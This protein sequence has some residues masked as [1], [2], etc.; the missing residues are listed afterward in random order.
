MKLIE[1]L[2]SDDVQAVENELWKLDIADEIAEGL[3]L[4][5]LQQIPPVLLRVGKNFIKQY[6]IVLRI[7]QLLHDMPRALW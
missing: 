6:S 7:W 2:N 5:D 1:A 3:H 4:S